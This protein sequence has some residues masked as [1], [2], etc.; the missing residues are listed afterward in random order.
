MIYIN[1]GGAGRC[2]FEGYHWPRLDRRNDSVSHANWKNWLQMLFSAGDSKQKRFIVCTYTHTRNGW[3]LV[4]HTKRLEVC[5]API[6]L[7][8]Y[9]L[10]FDFFQL[11]VF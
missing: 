8:R 3:R 9:L 4:T 1:V 2:R 5:F 7:H 10:V 11:I 6:P